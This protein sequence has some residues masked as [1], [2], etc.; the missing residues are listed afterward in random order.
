M[1][2]NASM[3]ALTFT[4][5]CSSETRGLSE[6]LQRLLATTNAIESLLSRTPIATNT[7]Q[8]TNDA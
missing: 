4:T 1:V 5:I 8:E 6:R 3:H 2:A 7:T